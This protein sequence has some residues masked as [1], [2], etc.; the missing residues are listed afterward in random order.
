MPSPSRVAPGQTLEGR[1][2]LLEE[3]GR[4]GMSTVFKATDLERDG[5]L[6]AVK[7]P[8]PQFASG[9]GS[10]SMFQREAEIG[11]RLDHPYILRFVPLAPRKN[12]THIVTEYVAGPTLAG[13]VGRGR[14][15]PEAEALA[16]HESP[17]RRRRLHAPAGDRALRSQARERHPLRR[18]IDSPDRPGDGARGREGTLRALRGRAAVR[19]HE[20]RR[21]RADWPQARADE[22]RH[23]CARS[24]ALRDAHR[25]GP[26]RGRRPVRHRE[27]PPD[28]RP[29]GAPGDLPGHQRRRPRRSSCAPCAA[30]RPSA[31]RAPRSSRP[32]STPPRR[33]SY[34]GSPRGWSR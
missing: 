3:I 30:I 2:H 8:L 22:R 15:L 23:L 12:R 19:H 34:R 27:R 26:L 17:L 5:Q 20:L 11:A 6:V 10:W 25:A 9:L 18:R 13:R 16:H 24:D 31:T 28:R 1:F 33:S 7:V 4:G 14:R 32:R 21:A 29:E